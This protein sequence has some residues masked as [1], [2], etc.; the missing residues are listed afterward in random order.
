MG[1]IFLHFQYA[2]IFR[3][4]INFFSNVALQ[5]LIAGIRQ[6]AVGVEMQFSWFSMHD[7]LHK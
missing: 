6:S 7:Q 5:Q 2:N 1:T 4:L 3:N